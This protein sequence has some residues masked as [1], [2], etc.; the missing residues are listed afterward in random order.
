MKGRA[1][2]DQAFVSAD[3]K[4]WYAVEEGRAYGGN[5]DR[6]TPR[7]ILFSKIF[8][9]RYLRLQFTSYHGHLSMRVAPLIAK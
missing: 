3:N 1:D 9:A 4:L 6:N 8:N 7:D 2:A 5:N